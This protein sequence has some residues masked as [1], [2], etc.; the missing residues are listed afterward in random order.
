MYIT[1]NCHCVLIHIEDILKKLTPHN[2]V[3]VQI[4]Y[5]FPACTSHVCGSS[6]SL[7][8]GS[9]QNKFAVSDKVI[10]MKIND[11]SLTGFNQYVTKNAL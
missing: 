4:L 7:Q 10:L 9:N 5:Q 3:C 6:V 1:I 11:H 8:I 2:Y